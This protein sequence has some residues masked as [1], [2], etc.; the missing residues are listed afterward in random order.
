ML[1]RVFLLAFM[2]L[3]F[4]ACGAFQVQQDTAPVFSS[5]H[6]IPGITQQQIDAINELRN[7]HDNFIY[8]M[9]LSDEAFI[10]SYGEPS[11]FS[12]RVTTWLSAFFDIP[13]VPQ[14]VMWCE[15]LD[16]LA[17][18]SIHFTGELK[19][20]PERELIFHMT[21]PIA[22][23]SIHAT[24]L[25]DSWTLENIERVR[26]LNFGFFKDSATYLVVRDSGV[27]EG[28]D[29]TFIS[30]ETEAYNLLQSGD[31]DAFVD[32]GTESMIFHGIPHT[33][34][35]LLSPFIFSN[36]A[37]STQN[38]ELAVIVDV[39]QLV[40]DNGGMSVLADLFVNG[41]WDFRRFKINY[42]LTDAETEFIE[43]NPV[44][45]VAAQ[46]FGYPISFFNS[47]EQ[48]HQGIA[49]DIL[50]QTEYLTG[51][52]F[53][54]YPG[55]QPVLLRDALDFVEFSDAHMAVGVIQPENIWG[56]FVRTDV[57]F[58]DRYALLSPFDT[59]HIT[60]NE[61]LYKRV[62]LI[63]YD[64]GHG[65]Y[66][67]LFLSWF[68][69]HPTIETFT[70]L[71]ELLM[72]LA[73]GEIDLAFSSTSSLLRLTN[74]FETPGFR[75]N[76]VFDAPYDIT[77]A[78]DMSY[79]PLVTILDKALLVLD[80]RSI[81][82]IWMDKTFDYSIRILE[83]RQ[84]LLTGIIALF[85]CLLVLASLLGYK[86]YSEGRRLQTLVDERTNALRHESAT[87]NAVFDAIPDILFCKDLELKHIR[88]NK[89]Y[90][91]SMDI[92]KEDIIGK[93]DRDFLGSLPKY[94]VDEYENEDNQIIQNQCTIEKEQTFPDKNG[95]PR[96]YEVMK[97]PLLLDDEPIGVLGI[98]RDITHRKEMEKEILIAS[99]AKTAF[100]ANMSHEI[101]T[102]MNS[103]VGFSELALEG[104]TSPKAREYLNR[105]IENSKSLLQ[106]INDVLDISKIESE[107]MEI[108][109]APFNI[110]E[111]F[112][113]CNT[114][115]VPAAIEKGLKLHF[116]TD[117]TP[118]Q[119]ILL[120]DSLRMHQIFVNLV[121]NAIKFT[122]IGTVRVA[123][124]LK[125]ETET[126]QTILFTVTDS[127]IGMTPEM[128]KKV[129]EP[130]GQADVSITRK[131]GGTGLGLPIVKR[132]V[133]LMGGEVKIESTK[134]VGS[135]FSFE[136]TFEAI[137]KE[138][139]ETIATTTV[140][141]IDKPLFS[142]EI[143]VCED[144]GMNQMV[145]S[146]HLSRVG[147]KP[148]IADNGKV[149]LEM[150]DSRIKKGK[151]P[152]DLIFMDIHMPVMDGLEAAEKIIELGCNTPIIALTANIMA[153]DKETYRQ[154]GMVECV[155]KPFT[156][157]E[158][159]SCLLKYIEPIQKT[160]EAEQ[161]SLQMPIADNDNELLD[162]L[163]HDFAKENKDTFNLLMNSINN[164]TVQ[165]HRMMHTLRSTAGLIG[166]KTLQNLCKEIEKMLK[167][168]ITVTED[169]WR[170]LENELSQ[171]LT[172]LAPLLEAD[173]NFIKSSI[174]PERAKNLLEQLES[175][176]TVRSPDC[177]NL[178]DD[179]R[180][181]PG[182]EALVSQIE[183]Y[184]FRKAI[185]TL[186]ELKIH[187]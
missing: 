166:E 32:K 1:L 172:T 152:F 46:C 64:A 9:V 18:Y 117:K 84:P 162:K 33:F 155:G 44:I 21:S 65:I 92:K 165:T 79:L 171:V 27:F 68:P 15:L 4:S 186:K 119:T 3:F 75:V 106:I 102:P 180:T 51:L 151:R 47:H 6:D 120:G 54:V 142:G 38:D 17:D 146:E 70:H 37:F 185:N 72:S 109:C 86:S 22:Q 76:H 12:A 118:G 49:F 83:A 135:K 123:A 163:R 20:T 170:E 7:T 58:E 160:S 138:D 39:M 11:G 122:D 177:L 168:K 96:F 132:L 127:G 164:D 24:Q 173:N 35:A 52:R 101:R 143:L 91:K 115:T 131:Y 50:R 124:L 181:I 147:L 53:E 103:I 56:R 23:R 174:A 34:S 182:T 73:N 16:G 126:H 98:S 105:I 112:A 161:L 183:S 55:Q 130:F 157:Q 137:D 104:E 63:G 100:I 82:D 14:I 140:G 136:L 85:W 97:T 141:N 94:I 41:I 107:K 144:N 169:K 8:G 67:E 40:L 59:P 111:V 88:I 167:N 150:I 80:T 99:K 13:F 43:N 184:D 139:N 187:F 128:M 148:T 110:K 89:R 87:L 116:Y 57:F 159:W 2:L 77:F 176:L 71:D 133:E 154:Y 114:A 121:S 19:S 45:T 60:V 36:S 69:H 5:Y 149:G 30:C 125:K 175:L 74:F 158:L 10:N 178:L 26:P 134:G 113:S 108:E 25:V 93:S 90:E 81:S 145:I 31:I 29:V 153:D 66:N 156:S 129:M 62:G 95:N 78:V 179:I 42:M 28:F 48:L 61:V